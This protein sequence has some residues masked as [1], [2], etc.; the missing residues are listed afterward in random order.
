LARSRCLVAEDHPALLTAL[1]EFLE[2]VDIEIAATA[3][4]GERAV[5]L[6]AETSPDVA[7]VDFRLPRLSGLE[8]VARLR[9]AAPDTRV[10]VYTADADEVVVRGALGAGVAAILLKESPLADVKRAIEC[11][12]DGGTYIDPALVAFAVGA[13]SGKPVLTEREQAVLT[14][15]AEGLSHDQIGE[16]LSISGETVRAHARKAAIRL[17]ASTR[18]EAVATALRRGLIS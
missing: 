18:T 17:G 9:E 10:V 8:F 7:L 4:D 13:E 14:L 1:V 12:L 5:A 3:A 11:V 2:S 15:I 6:A 16:R